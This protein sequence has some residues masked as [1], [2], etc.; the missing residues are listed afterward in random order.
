LYPASF[1]SEK[2]L[3]DQLPR[4]EGVQSSIALSSL[5]RKESTFLCDTMVASV[6]SKNSLLFRVSTRMNRKSSGREHLKCVSVFRGFWQLDRVFGKPQGASASAA[7]IAARRNR[8]NRK[9]HT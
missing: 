7:G 1:G 5:F 9:R 2:K 4:H 3:A 6:P 8:L